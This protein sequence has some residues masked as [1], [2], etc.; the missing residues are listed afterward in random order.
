MF[1]ARVHP[2]FLHISYNI[3][4]TGGELIGKMN[5][6]VIENAKTTLHAEELISQIRA[7]WDEWDLK[8]KAEKQGWWLLI[9][10]LVMPKLFWW[11]TT[12]SKMYANLLRKFASKDD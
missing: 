5:E 8:E 3:V 1:Y 10:S 11:L 12:K 9:G 6:L 4:I 7:I 2:N